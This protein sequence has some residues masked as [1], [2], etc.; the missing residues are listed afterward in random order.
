MTSPPHW[1]S[2]GYMAGNPNGA[3]ARGWGFPEISPWP[4]GRSPIA[5]L[6]A[7]LTV[8]TVNV[9]GLRAAAKKGFLEWLASTDADVVCLQETRAEPDQLPVSVRA[10]EGWHVVF[11]PG[12]R[13]RNG[14][15][16]YSRAEPATSR[17]GF[18]SGEF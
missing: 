8:S 11:A 1:N 6:G 16:V 12:A 15:A 3:P 13:G 5:T 14:V 9:N 2:T 10:P 4:G 18:G 17:I 7:V